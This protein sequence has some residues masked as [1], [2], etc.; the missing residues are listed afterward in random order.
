MRTEQVLTEKG[1]HEDAIISYS[2]L[3][4]VFKVI[5][6]HEVVLLGRKRRDVL[7]L[8]RFRVCFEE[9]REDETYH[10]SS[11]NQRD[12]R[13]LFASLSFVVG[14]QSCGDVVGRRVGEASSVFLVFKKSCGGL[15][16]V[17]R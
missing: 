6:G 7:A 9:L 14:G 15:N 17:K 13:F 16:E 1:E 5:P 3:V 11:G 12:A 8:V 2:Q 10:D 4:G